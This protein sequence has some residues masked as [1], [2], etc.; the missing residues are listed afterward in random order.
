MMNR[1]RV[2]DMA[3]YEY[4][5]NSLDGMCRL[6]GEGYNFSYYRLIDYLDL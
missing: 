6:F 1:I 3:K 2:S 5:M 4:K